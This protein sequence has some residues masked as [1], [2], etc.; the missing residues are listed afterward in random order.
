MKIKNILTIFLV[1]TL[2]YAQERPVHTYSI[3]AIDKE[4]GQMGGAVQSHWFSVGSLVLWANPGVGV[5]ATQSFVRPEY[6]PELLNMFSR[7][8]SPQFALNMLLK[9]DSE[10]NVRQIGAVDIKG[11]SVTFTGKDCIIYASGLQG[12]GYA[13]QANIMANPG[14]PEAMEKAYLST[15]GSLADKLY[16]A[17]VAAENMGGDLRG[18][19]SAA[20]L[21]V[22][23]EKVDN[24]LS[25]KI[26]DIRVDD[27]SDPL[28]DLD[29]LMRIQKAY[30]FANEGDVLAAEGKLQEALDAYNKAS[31]LYPENVE[32]L[33]WGAVILCTDNKFDIAKP[34]F[35][36]IFKVDS[37]LREMVPRLENHPMFPLSEEM[38]KKI[39]DIK[40]FN[41]KTQDT[42]QKKVNNKSLRGISNN[43][44]QVS[45]IGYTD[46]TNADIRSLKNHHIYKDLDYDDAWTYPEEEGYIEYINRIGSVKNPFKKGEPMNADIQGYALNKKGERYTLPFQDL[47][48]GITTNE[49]RMAFPADYLKS[50]GMTDSDL[51]RMIEKPYEFLKYLQVNNT[52]HN[53]GYYK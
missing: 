11:R 36:K 21:V 14:V 28:S 32:L 19:Q 13:I 47:D 22:P 25:S 16:A 30:I 15:E 29:R 46:M 43:F 48:T 38:V 7:G 2:V 4:S 1:T 45:G 18:K 10:Q 44:K 51:S 27:S 50:L 40:F 12:E 26:Y 31:E 5:V 24:L 39:L 41:I 52:S 49:Y 42:T 20:M 3:V 8:V 34:M 23:L 9:E 33:F 37:D 53:K 17:L 35:E 6:G